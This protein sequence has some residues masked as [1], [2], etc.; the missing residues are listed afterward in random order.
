MMRT[1]G[2]FCQLRNDCPVN[3]KCV[4]NIKQNGANHDCKGKVSLSCVQKD[5]LKQTF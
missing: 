2:Q 4:R 1:E 3:L 5:K